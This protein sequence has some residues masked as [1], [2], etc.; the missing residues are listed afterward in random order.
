MNRIVKTVTLVLGLA[1][2]LLSTQ[3]Q[4]QKPSKVIEL[5]IFVAQAATRS[6]A[7]TVAEITFIP[8][9]ASRVTYQLEGTLTAFD[10]EEIV[11]S[12]DKEKVRYLIPWFVVR[13]VEIKQKRK[14]KARTG[15]LVGLLV[16]GAAGGIIGSQT[17]FCI[18]DCTDLTGFGIV[19]GSVGG[20]L[21]GATVGA[22]LGADRWERLPLDDYQVLERK[23]LENR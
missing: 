12:Q 21:V 16:G 14:S 20:L 2:S 6:K 3:A 4:Q 18:F 10:R 17:E 15:A 11:L 1:P 13:A 22:A 23:L 5:R 7:G 8:E 9:A 19:A